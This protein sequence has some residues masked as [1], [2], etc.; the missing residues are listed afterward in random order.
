VLNAK[1][2]W[3]TAQAVDWLVA[4]FDAL[5]SIDAHAPAVQIHDMSLRHG[6]VMGGHRSHQSGRDVDLTYFTRDCRRSCGQG[7][8]EPHALDAA[9]QWELL[10]YWL[11][12]DQLE[13]AFID[14]ALQKPLFQAARTAGATDSELARWFQFPR[15]ATTS[16]GLIRHVPKHADHV[17]VRFRCSH[18]DPACF[19]RR[20]ADAATEAGSDES[21][22][23]LLELLE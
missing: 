15:S 9:R 4:A 5:L 22:R 20:S 13:F 12:R 6:G 17:H 8:V 3:G 19:G 14:H 18:G 21:E 11:K 16:A 2:A 10:S 1:R 23:E 7:R